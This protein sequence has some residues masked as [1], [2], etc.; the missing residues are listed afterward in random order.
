MDN[1]ELWYVRFSLDFE[2]QT[3]ACGDQEG[4]LHVWNIQNPYYIRHSLLE[5]KDCRQIVSTNCES[6]FFELRSRFVKQLFLLM[7][8]RS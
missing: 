8:P 3:L 7:E 6:L 1:C 5:D 4:R 2:Y